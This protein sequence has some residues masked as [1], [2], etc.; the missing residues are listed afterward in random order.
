MNKWQENISLIIN[1]SYTL[2]TCK[3]KPYNLS[4]G[5]VG[6][7]KA[8]PKYNTISWS[9]VEA[10]NGNSAI[11]IERMCKALYLYAVNIRNFRQILFLSLMRQDSC[12]KNINSQIT[13]LKICHGNESY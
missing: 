2:N 3:K 5:V 4:W 13:G 6:V 11:K 10:L 1:A 8:I 9:N 12:L 7:V